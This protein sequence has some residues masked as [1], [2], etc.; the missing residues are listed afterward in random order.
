MCVTGTSAGQLCCRVLVRKDHNYLK[1]TWMQLV[2]HSSSQDCTRSVHLFSHWHELPA[3]QYPALGC[4]LPP[5]GVMHRMAAV[6]LT[7]LCWLR[8]W[9]T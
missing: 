1:V 5:D 3:A 2:E 4:C 9:D 8:R 6:V 7:H